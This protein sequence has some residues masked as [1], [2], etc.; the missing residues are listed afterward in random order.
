MAIILDESSVEIQDES[1]SFILDEG[2][3][4]DVIAAQLRGSFKII[5]RIDYFKIIR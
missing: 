5:D 1:G 2:L 4:V 3:L